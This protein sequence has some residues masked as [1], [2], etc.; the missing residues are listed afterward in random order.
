MKGKNCSPA[1]K[2]MKKMMAK[3]DKKMGKKVMK[4]KKK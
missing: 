3:V 1:M 4:G 2:N